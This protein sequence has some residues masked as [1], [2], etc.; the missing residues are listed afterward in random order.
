MSAVEPDRSNA[1]RVVDPVTMV[2]SAIADVAP[3]HVE[4]LAT[5]DHDVDV[6]L[7]LGLDSMDHLAV[8]DRL[9]GHL[10]EP[11]TAHDYPRLTT[12]RALADHVRTAGAN[13]RNG[14]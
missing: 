14:G 10:G 5:I 3:E 7:E 8:L 2:L 9:G 12:V 13:A 1:H 11:I 6:W 4:E